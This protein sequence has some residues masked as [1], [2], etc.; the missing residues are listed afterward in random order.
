[1][2]HD[3]F[4]SYSSK[5]KA[6]ADAVCHALE[7]ARIRVWM[8]PRDI[9]PGAGW[10]QSII[11][12]INGARVMVLVFS[13][14]ANGS[15]QIERE[16]E[17]SVHKGLAILPVRIEDVPP[18]EALEY[19]ISAPHWLDAFPAPHEP[20]FQRL[21]QDV[22]RLLNSQ[23]VRKP[24]TP[25]E[26]ARAAQAEADAAARVEVEGRRRAEADAAQRRILF[27]MLLVFTALGGLIYFLTAGS[28]PTPTFATKVPAAST[29]STR[30]CGGVTLSSLSTRTPAPLTANEECVLQA[31]DVFKEC[32]SCPEMVVVP[33]GS[34]TMGSPESE[35]GRSGNEGP[36]HRAT[37]GK[38]FAAGRFAVTFDEWDA[39]VADGACGGYRP[40]D[41]GWGR[42]RRPVI[43]VSWNHAEAYVAWLSRKTGKQY[44][45]LSE[46]EWEYAARAGTTTPFS[47]GD[48]ITTDQVNYDGRYPYAGWANG[49][50][51]AMT[52]PVGS[53]PPNA[54]G[55]YEMHGNAWQ[56]VEDTYH[57]AYDGAPSD[58]SAW[59]NSRAG[60]RVLRGGSWISIAQDVRSAFRNVYAPEVRSVYISFRCARVQ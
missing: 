50:Y 40:D 8:A 45:L 10:A 4:L 56:W 58:G 43:N 38:S 52:V 41:R 18:S 1:M 14:N 34:F 25:D 29:V 23:F 32:P 13:G 31:K 22:K 17:R 15:P 53:L 26:I 35:Q 42:G 60:E 9:L 19:F 54:W 59:L 33:A 44:R 57:S 5:D 46:A 12:A 51:R 21:A 3:I 28:A 39:C 55:L 11:G 49:L 36:Q 16:V 6:A 27:G 7:T 47:F 48:N 37:I 30:P 20:H 24:A 2:A